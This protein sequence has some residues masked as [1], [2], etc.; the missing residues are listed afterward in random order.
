MLKKIWLI[1]TFILFVTSCAVGPDY[2]R[3][4]V[5]APSQFKEAKNKAVIAPHKSKKSSKSI[6]WKLAQPKDQYDRGKWWLI[7]NDP[8]LNELED[9]LVSNNQSVQNAYYNYKQARALVDEAAA[10]FFPTVTG[11]LS[12]SRQKGGG[13]S[14]FISNTTTGV[15]TGTAVTGGNSSS[16]I[17]NSRSWLIDATWE[18]D[19]WGLVR[20]TVEASAAGAQ[21]SEALFASTR[22]SLEGMLAQTYFELRGLDAIQKL[23]NDTV[24][25]DK[26][27]L[28]LTLHRYASGVAARG[29]IVQAQS[30][31]E[32]AEAQAINNGILRGQYEHAIAVLIG[33]PPA[34]LSLAP[35]PFHAVPP[36]IP[37]SVPSVLLERRPDIAQAERLM[38]QANAQIG[39]AEAA[40]FPTLTLTSTASTIP[41][42]PLFSVPAL[43][44][45]LGMQLAETIIDGGLRAATVRAA[46]AGYYASVANYRQVVLAAFQN[47]E[48]NLISLR[49]LNDQI[50]VERKAVASAKLG[51]KLVINQYKSGTVPY[52]SV[53]TAEINAFNIEQ[54]AIN[55][56]YQRMV[57][58]VGLVEALGGEW[59]A[60]QIECI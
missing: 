51:L 6:E 15:S 28:Q 49:I 53:I 32:A 37:V 19:L 39:V 33:I 1:S 27:S 8:K 24:A 2:K 22:L 21:A 55:A 14:S 43:N 56:E 48:D 5:D 35:G 52:S 57:S 4:L 45:S 17:T 29:D 42:G 40:Y 46:K 41:K 36:A 23:L 12:M 60:S 25:S 9:Q 26:S 3:P 38:Q 44:W 11:S 34:E 13:G 30:V 18:P 10:S 16:T 31:L 20:R 47:V 59:D 7:F 54:T 58:A 50:V